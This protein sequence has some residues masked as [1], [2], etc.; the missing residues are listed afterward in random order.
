MRKRIGEL[1]LVFVLAMSGCSASLASAAEI[2]GAQYDSYEDLF[3]D[4]QNDSYDD[5]FD[6]TW[7]E[8]YDP[9]E[10]EESLTLYYGDKGTFLAPSSWTDHSGMYV[11]VASADFE[12]KSA[13]DGVLSIDENGNYEVIGVGTTE[14]EGRFYDASGS[15]LLI[16]TYYIS[17][18]VDMSGVKLDKT[19]AK[20]YVQQGYY[21]ASSQFEFHLKSGGKP[22]PTDARDYE[23]SCSSSNSG[24]YV[25]AYMSDDSTVVL[26]TMGTGNTT[27]TLV[28]NGKEFKV[29]LRVIEVG[30]NKN[31]LLLT[32]KQ[33]SQLKTTGLKTGVKWSSSKPGVVKVTSD[34][35]VTALK[36]GNAVIKAKVG[37]FTVGCAVSV[38]SENRYKTIKK[39]VSIAKN[40]TY[41]QEKRMQ[42]GYYDCSSLTWYAY[43][44]SG[45]NFGNQYYAPVAASQ[46]Q[47]CVE[48]KKNI[49]G[50]LSAANVKN[51][52]LNAGDLMFEGGSNNGRYRGIYHVEMITGY[53]CY[54][55]DESGKPVLGLTWA[56]RPDNYYWYSGQLVCRP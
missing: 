2:D 16:K 36:N 11:P 9:D 33:T 19:S 43:K 48:R 51:M 45:I 10:Q 24:I 7:D 40:S 25:N 15:L 56:S 22:I 29:K 3:G 54:G 13:W 41:S 49:K 37:G 17:A 5:L 18:K 55:F 38:V 12:L 20:S 4:E 30:I 34:G 46:A 1:M 42:A 23:V 8:T 27:V 14:V 21:Y 28:I 52:K 39:A 26:Y 53:V 32:V 47:W 31:S 6:E 50:G 35:K 44:L